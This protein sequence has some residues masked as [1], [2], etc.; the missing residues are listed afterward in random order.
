MNGQPLLDLLQ[1]GTG[2]LLD[3]HSL[4]QTDLQTGLQA[5]LS[6][7]GG[8]AHRLLDLL[9][10]LLVGLAGLLQLLRQSLRIGT[11]VG[12]GLVQ[13]AKQ[14]GMVVQQNI[15]GPAL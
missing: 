10:R 8:L 1:L 12:I 4:L 13:T 5:L 3:G 14:Q 9:G 2:L 11:Q 15:Y 7:L 6:G